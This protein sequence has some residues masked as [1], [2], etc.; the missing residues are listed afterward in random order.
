VLNGAP[1]EALTVEYF[2]NPHADPSG[3]GGGRT[4]LGTDLVTPNADGFTTMITSYAAES[5]IF[6]NVR[7]GPLLVLVDQKRFYW[8]AARI[9][10]FSPK[11]W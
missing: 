3:F 1:G 9:D 4:Y 11:S 6:G 7:R 10:T 2:R 8:G 5:L